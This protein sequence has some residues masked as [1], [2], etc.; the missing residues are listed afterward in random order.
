MRAPTDRTTANDALALAAPL[1]VGA[2]GT[3]PT[4]KTIPT[5]YR[6]LDKPSW[7]PPDQIFGPVW[8]ALYALMGIALVL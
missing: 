8:T 3:I 7:N 2:L 1:L 5:W 4:L 6:T